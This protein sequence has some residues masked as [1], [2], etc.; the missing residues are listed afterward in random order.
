MQQNKVF[1]K[2]IFESIQGEGPY[3]GENQLF[4]RFSNCNLNCKYCDTDFKSDLKEY[5]KDDLI[6]E[7][8][9]YK[10]IHSISLT[11]GEPLINANFLKQVLPDIKQKI[12]LETNGTLSNELKKI[13]DYIDIIAMDIKIPSATGNTDLFDEH[14]EFIKTAIKKELFIKVVFNEKITDEET[15]KILKLA[16]KY[17]L[18]IILQP[19]SNGNKIKNDIKTINKVFYKIRNQYKNERLIP[20]LHK[21]LDAK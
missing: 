7:I 6:K 1:I 3:M 15:D 10:H 20:Q 5:T 19:E 18:P 13:I 2:E 11:G 16:S 8:N 12:Y 9:K 21:F 4:I 17:N 14:E